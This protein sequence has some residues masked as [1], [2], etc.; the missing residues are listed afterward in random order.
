DVRLSRRCRTSETRRTE[1]A[2][3]VKTTCGGEGAGRRAR[4]ARIRSRLEHRRIRGGRASARRIERRG[5]R[6]GSYRAPHSRALAES[7]EGRLRLAP[8]FGGE[9]TDA[10]HGSVVQRE[11]TRL[12]IVLE[13][14]EVAL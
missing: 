3:Q 12:Q 10:A 2:T 6:D 14:S 1:A 9:A 8:Q 7:G 11:V 4:K 5:S 13:L